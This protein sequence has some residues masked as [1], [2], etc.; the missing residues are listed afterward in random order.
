MSYNK[1]PLYYH[2]KVCFDELI[3]IREKSIY[4]KIDGLKVWMPKKCCR[5]L[6]ET[7]NTVYIWNKVYE[8]NMIKAKAFID[9]LKNTNQENLLN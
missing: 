1:D 2:T 3:E 4:F 8:P 5:K 9:N 6:N 7:D